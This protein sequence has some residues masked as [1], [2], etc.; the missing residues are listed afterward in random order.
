MDSRLLQLFY[1]LGS[2]SLRGLRGILRDFGGSEAEAAAYLQH[3]PPYLRWQLQRWERR[4]LLAGLRGDDPSK[5]PPPAGL[6][7]ALI[8]A[9]AE[10]GKLPVSDDELSSIISL[11]R[12]RR[13]E[14]MRSEQ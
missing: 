14:G 6:Q 2:T 3:I 5:V 1:R 8:Q 12:E 10:A 11:L 4:K 7:I 13:E 9:L